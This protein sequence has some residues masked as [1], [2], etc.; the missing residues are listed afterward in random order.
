MEKFST[1][2]KLA[3]IIIIA[4]LLIIPK[5][6]IE[7]TVG[8]RQERNFY[9]FNEASLGWGGEQTVSGV[10]L[11]VPVE[12]EAIVEKKKEIKTNGNVETEIVKES[13][14]TIKYLHILPEILNVSSVIRPVIKY[15]SLYEFIFYET[16][17]DIT[18]NF[19]LKDIAD[20]NIGDG[21]IKWEEASI[22]MGLVSMEGISEAVHVR[23]DQNSFAMEHSN[24]FKD[25]FDSGLS[26]KI[27]IDYSK[28]KLI[29][30]VYSL[31]MRGSRELTFIPLGK[32]N[33]I[34]IK[35]QWKDPSFFGSF[36]PVNNEI[37]DQGFSAGWKILDL[38][39]NYPQSWIYGE[40]KEN[41][42]GS[43]FGVRLINPVDDYCKIH[44]AVKYLFLFITLTFAMFFLIETVQKKRI[45]PIQYL[46]VGSAISIFFI[47]LLSISEHI[48]FDL[49]Y[50]ISALAVSAMLCLY[51]F[52]VLKSRKFGLMIGS[53]TAILYLFLFILL[54]NQ[55]Y[56]ML[57]GSVGL[58]ISLAIIMYATRKTNW[59][60][61]HNSDEIQKPE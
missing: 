30:F 35:S 7:E 60:S 50:V 34:S 17:N 32:I 15:R 26:A 47:L 43:E 57:L 5:S 51:S 24:Y 22:V 36:I 23:I 8:E 33:N 9:T 61:I 20:Y 21:N 44:R 39:R 14:K 45:H 53:S 40:V 56:S 12:Y 46:L 48:A 4:L 25:V 38:N 3:V 2:I 55:D 28:G 49:A 27:K 59:Y 10:M 29:D 11:Y 41:I 1:T 16:G 31:N 52:S 54:K 37:N 42:S 58:F 18:G 13:V 6:M 19:I